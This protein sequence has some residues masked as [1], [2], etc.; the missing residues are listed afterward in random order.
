ML[1]RHALAAT[2]AIGLLTSG[3]SGGGTPPAT[4]TTAVTTSATTSV[5]TTTTPAATGT[6]TP[7]AE[8]GTPEATASGTP[9]ETASGT[10]TA[11]ETLDPAYVKLKEEGV[12]LA[13]G[14][15]YADA[16]PALEKA[17]EVKPDDPEVHFY[18]MLSQGNL[19]ETPTPK[20]PAYT[21]AKKVLDLAPGSTMAE[22]ARDYILSAESEPKKPMKDLPA[23]PIGP[24]HD[25]LVKQNAVYTMEAP[26]YMIPDKKFGDDLSK[27][28]W[29]LELVPQSV[30][31]KVLVPK[32][33]Q[34]TIH[35]GLDYYYGK[36]S[37]KGGKPRPEEF[38]TNMYELNVFEIE[39][40]SGDMKGKRGWYVNQLDRFLGVDEKENPVFGVKI[41]PRLGIRHDGK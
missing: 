31:E 34:F 18:L 40:E 39:I 12:N 5:E 37:W 36:T 29:Y 20:S 2:L 1:H 16:V 35:S 27:E 10:P 24:P 13:L 22:R 32:G 30:T 6:E 14:K 15:G 33:T 17:L 28:L 9:G 7:G 4:P 23:D 19:E 11:E 3:C 21:H 26:V 38:D 25:W 41:G 8:T